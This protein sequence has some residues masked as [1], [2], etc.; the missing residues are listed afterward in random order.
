[1]MLCV[2]PLAGTYRLRLLNAPAEDN[3]RCRSFRIIFWGGVIAEQLLDAEAA[4]ITHNIEV[5]MILRSHSVA[6]RLAETG[7]LLSR[8]AGFD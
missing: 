2:A 7:S 4:T 1:M 8:E 3:Q 5:A 6:Y